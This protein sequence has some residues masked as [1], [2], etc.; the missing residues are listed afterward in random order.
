MIKSYQYKEY[1]YTI[2]VQLNAKAE[3]CMNGERW[4][5]VS[6]DC[7]DFFHRESYIDRHDLLGTITLFQLAIETEINHL[8]NQKTGI[9]KVLEDMG[10]K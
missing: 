6:I 1:H 2:E 8:E 10:F 4:D 3:R 7:K 5:S 9:E